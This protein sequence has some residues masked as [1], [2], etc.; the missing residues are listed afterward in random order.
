VTCVGGMTSND[1][2]IL[3][4]FLR[5][6]DEARDTGDSLEKAVRRFLHDSDQDSHELAV[7]KLEQALTT[8]ALNK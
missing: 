3:A 7:E 6:R 2:A 4:R 5:Q 8:Y 1:N